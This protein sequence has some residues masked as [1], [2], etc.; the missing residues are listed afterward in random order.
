VHSGGKKVIDAA[1]V[2]L[3]LTRHDVRL[4]TQLGYCATTAS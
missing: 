3:G 1:W 2:N 4:R